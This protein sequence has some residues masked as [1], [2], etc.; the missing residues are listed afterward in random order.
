MSESDGLMPRYS[1]ASHSVFNHPVAIQISKDPLNGSRICT[2]AYEIVLPGEAV[3]LL[4]YCI[5]N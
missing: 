1:L 4:Y 3:D 5:Q 2:S